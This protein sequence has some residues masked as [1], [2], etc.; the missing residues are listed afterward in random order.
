VDGQGHLEILHNPTEI[1]IK[2]SEMARHIGL[3][4]CEHFTQAQKA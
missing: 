3:V 2:T 4:Q 1:I